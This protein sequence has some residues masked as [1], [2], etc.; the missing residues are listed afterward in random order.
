MNTVRINGPDR[1][2]SRAI[3]LPK[4][5]T[6]AINAALQTHIPPV[7][8]T[9]SFTNDKGRSIGVR[10]YPLTIPQLITMA[11]NGDL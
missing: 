1:K 11:R 7:L 2:V 4:R 6:V 9:E 5:M 3:L 10:G 8:V